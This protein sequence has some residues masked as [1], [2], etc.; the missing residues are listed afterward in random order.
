MVVKKERCSIYTHTDDGFRIVWRRIWTVQSTHVVESM[1]MA[2]LGKGVEGDQHCFRCNLWSVHPLAS[3]SPTS[4]R[5]PR[6]AHSIRGMAQGGAAGQQQQQQRIMC[7]LRMKHEREEK[8]GT[9]GTAESTSPVDTQ[10]VLP[11]GGKD[12][13]RAVRE[14]M[15]HTPTNCYHWFDQCFTPFL[16]WTCLTTRTKRE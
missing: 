1:G 5:D 2:G 15:Q 16:P 3:F 4:A 13:A 14:P 9:I 8:R 12:A 11:F 10:C 7:G 6:T